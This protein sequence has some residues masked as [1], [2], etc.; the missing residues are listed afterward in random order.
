LYNELA[1]FSSMKVFSIFAIWAA[2]A[3]AQGNQECENAKVIPLPEPLSIESIRMMG[4]N[5]DAVRKAEA[6]MRELYEE[7]QK[8][9]KNCE[10][11]P[12]PGELSEP[13]IPELAAFRKNEATTKS[14]GNSISSLA[15]NS[16]FMASTAW[17][18][19]FS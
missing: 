13:I 17:F 18:L 5:V 2:V 7:A 4:M 11:I 16:L 19:V 6:K 8:A 3:Y 14:F 1:I 12:G 10:K 9:L 15:K